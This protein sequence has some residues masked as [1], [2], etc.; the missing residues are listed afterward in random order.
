MMKNKKKKKLDEKLLDMD[1]SGIQT[2]MINFH[3]IGKGSVCFTVLIITCYT[4]FVV[5]FG[6][7]ISLHL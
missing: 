1:D 7:E 5:L 4:F 3:K 2:V 6:C